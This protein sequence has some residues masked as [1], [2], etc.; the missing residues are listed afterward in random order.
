LVSVSLRSLPSTTLGGG[1]GGGG[2]GGGVDG[3]S[4]GGGASSLVAVFEVADDGG[5]I[6]MA[7]T[8]MVSQSR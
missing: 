1:S 3:A 8:E 4:I 6:Y 2:G 5:S 7:Q